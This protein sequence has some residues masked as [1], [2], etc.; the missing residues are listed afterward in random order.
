[1][2]FL[3]NCFGVIVGYVVDYAAMKSNCLLKIRTPSS[4]F[5]LADTF[6]EDVYTVVAMMLRGSVSFVM[7]RLNFYTKV[8]LIL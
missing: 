2:S 5:L 8:D 4:L 7:L 1:M 3:L 6:G